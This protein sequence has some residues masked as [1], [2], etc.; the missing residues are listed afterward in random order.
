MCTRIRLLC[1]SPPVTTLRMKPTRCFPFL[2]ATFVLAG[3]RWSCVRRQRRSCSEQ[4]PPPALNN[5]P[6]NPP[7]P[8]VALVR[9]VAH[10]VGAYQQ[11]RTYSVLSAE[12]ILELEMERPVEP[13][14]GGC[15]CF[16]K[17]LVPRWMAVILASESVGGS[18][19]VFVGP[20]CCS[21]FVWPSVLSR[22]V[23]CC[24]GGLVVVDVVILVLVAV[25]VMVE[26]LG[27]RV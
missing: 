2:F 18:D 16:N 26:W 7:L 5:A 3:M 24:H 11:S 20:P 17:P 23:L 19:R 25:V 10:V 6:R 27:A 15:G 22:V 21:V 14:A 1:S 13:V 4:P 9:V 12:E 8:R